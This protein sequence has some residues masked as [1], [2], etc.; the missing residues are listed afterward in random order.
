MKI[1]PPGSL[2]A[3]LLL[4]SSVSI[5]SSQPYTFGTVV[6][7]VSNPGSADG[8]NAAAQFTSP[9]G[10]TLSP[11]GDLFLMDGGALRKIASWGG[12]WAVTT[13]AGMIG[14]NSFADGTNS[15]ARF[16]DPQ[17]VAVDAAGNIYVADTYNHAIRRVA[18]DGNNW[19][20]TTIA[21]PKP[22]YASFGM[23]DGLNNAARFH[24]PYGIC[25]D[26]ATNL[27]VADSWNHTIRKIST[28]GADWV[29]STL[30]GLPGVP[31]SDNGTN[32]VARFNTP[33]SVALDPAG[34][35]YV[36]DFKNNIIRKVTPIA[37]EWAVT[38]P[39]GTAGSS[40]AVDA[41]GTAARFYLPQ[42]VTLDA[43]QNVFVADSG[44]NLIRKIS[45]AG[46]VATLAG[47]S[48]VP[49]SVDGT[50]NTAL[51]NQPYGIAVDSTG[52]LYVS[53]FLGYAIRQ[54][55]VAPLLRIALSGQQAV[56]SWPAGLVSYVPEYSS[57][58][59]RASW[60]PLPTN[61]LV[62][63]NDTFLLN[64]GLTM[65]QRFFRLHQQ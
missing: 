34:N 33:V 45:P 20:V 54:G 4:V 40:G 44:N 42:S 21:G 16:R 5:A 63:D 55:R 58:L 31:G 46:L 35:V 60:A 65:G 59:P 38:T 15:N 13:I 27:Y 26:A 2:L 22:P 17:G 11:G 8:T 37:G 43:A 64:T 47:S 10:L 41:M 7:S 28:V 1:L 9:K 51:F 25:V 49:G 14:Q 48:G 24:N 30:A 53:D 56:L 29:V 39:A 61:G 57:G 32:M 6:G 62:L 3:S 12:N 19:V 36:A 50:G 23:T 18:Y 52:T